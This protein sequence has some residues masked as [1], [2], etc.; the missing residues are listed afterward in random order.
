MLCAVVRKVRITTSVVARTSLE[1]SRANLILAKNV[2]RVSFHERINALMDSAHPVLHLVFCSFGCRLVESAE[3]VALRNVPQREL[4]LLLPLL[5]LLLLSTW[6]F[7][8]CGAG[9][10]TGAG[11]ASPVGVAE[12]SAPVA[13]GPC[14]QDAANWR[15]S[16]LLAAADR[17]GSLK[18]LLKTPNCSS[19]PAETLR[20][21]VNNVCSGLEDRAHICTHTGERRWRLMGRCSA[22]NTRWSRND[23]DQ[24]CRVIVLDDRVHP[25]YLCDPS[26]RFILRSR[27]YTGR[28]INPT[29]W[30]RFCTPISP[31]PAHHLKHTLPWL[32]V[33]SLDI[34]GRHFVRVRL[35]VVQNL[36][37]DVVRIV[38][39]PVAWV[40]RDCW[41]RSC[42]WE[43]VRRPLAVLPVLPVFLEKPL[44]LSVPIGLILQIRLSLTLSLLVS[45]VHFLPE[46]PLLALLLF[47]QI[48]RRSAFL[49][50]LPLGFFLCFSRPRP[51]HLLLLRGQ[52]HWHVL[53]LI[54]LEAEPAGNI[55][56]SQE[57]GESE[58]A[59]RGVGEEEQ[60]EC[61]GNG[62]CFDDV[63]GGGDNLC[64]G[65]RDRRIDT[66]LFDQIT[67]SDNLGLD[68]ND[69]GEA[70]AG[71]LA[72]AAID[73]FL[74]SG[75]MGLDSGT[76]GTILTEVRD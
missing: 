52:W 32:G 27:A 26:S 9:V 5:L 73:S 39:G 38:T 37:V 4:M 34:L 12:C 17:Q 47:F 42:G 53:V 25:R 29:V 18:L 48:P 64:D 1:D 2:L 43:T 23:V 76:F 30:L 13:A 58:H 51:L 36:T 68:V 61:D 75:A 60:A 50:C 6:A 62:G 46:L 56:S 65:E 40:A 11:I 3:R 66:S 28:R 14:S 16:D 63:H 71:L 8:A 54:D 15:R 59:L 19:S 55:K 22:R 44:Q 74:S 70:G 35:G 7:V 45:A 49:L 67:I 21:G 31:S 20:F 41:T 72:F 10:T 69:L 57:D 33:R 24:T